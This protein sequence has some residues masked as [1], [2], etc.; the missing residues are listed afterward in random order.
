MAK[1]RIS[2]VTK[3]PVVKRNKVVTPTTTRRFGYAAY[4]V[5]GLSS[6]TDT[7]LGFNF[8]KNADPENKDLYISKVY[9]NPNNKT[10]REEFFDGLG[11]T[12]YAF[13][14]TGADDQIELSET[15]Q[16]HFD[17]FQ[18][19]T[20][21]RLVFFGKDE[22]IPLLQLSDQL[23]ISG[24]QIQYGLADYD[25]PSGD[26]ADRIDPERFYFT[27]KIEARIHSPNQRSRSTESN[28]LIP[29]AVVGQ[30]CPPK[31]VPSS[32]LLGL[33]NVLS[34]DQLVQNMRDILDN[35]TQVMESP[36]PQEVDGTIHG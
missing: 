33:S 24:C 1:K 34:P 32:L 20:G 10:F 25:P 19:K 3:T 5:E 22:L 4:Q 17:N 8:R 21:I 13:A 36:G 35:W 31:W 15:D 12:R 18:F 16:L 11:Q 29:T 14:G 9:F 27:L 6:V 26:P 2:N 28:D 7:L 30:P 23:L